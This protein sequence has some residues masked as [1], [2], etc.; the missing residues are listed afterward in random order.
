MAYLAFLFSGVSGTVWTTNQ[1]ADQ[2]TTFHQLLTVISTVLLL[3]TKGYIHCLH[4]MEITTHFVNWVSE[5]AHQRHTLKYRI[6]SEILIPLSLLH[7]LFGII[8]FSSTVMI[9]NIPCS[10]P[11][12]TRYWNLIIAVLAYTPY[13]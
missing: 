4:L 13:T 2:W 6:S 7:T 8:S 1:N 10:N 11:I 5:Y 9:C 12:H 3:V